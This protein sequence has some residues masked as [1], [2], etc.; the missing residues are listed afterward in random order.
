MLG[1][2]FELT[3]DGTTTTL[4]TAVS[5]NISA[6][7]TPGKTTET[8]ALHFGKIAAHFQ[9]GPLYQ[10]SGSLTTPPCSDGVIWLVAQKPLPVNVKTF[11]GFKKIMKFNAR[12]TQN[13]LGQQNLIQLAAS[14]LTHAQ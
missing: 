4:L 8:C 3:T 14:Q 5:H 6:I 11:L 2:L 7:A 12:Y 1:A 13:T 10:Y 9:T